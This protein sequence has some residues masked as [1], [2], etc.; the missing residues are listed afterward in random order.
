[1]AWALQL[2]RQWFK[3]TRADRPWTD[4][5]LPP[6]PN[7]LALLAIA[8]ITEVD[9]GNRTFFWTDRWLHI[10]FARKEKWLRQSTT[11]DSYMIFGVVCPEMA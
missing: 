3:K 10:V 11:L 2:R 6:H 9:N 5:E 7:S 4:L 8:I 1:M